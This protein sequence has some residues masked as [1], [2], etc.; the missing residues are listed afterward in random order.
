V[1]SRN[2]PPG[3][4]RNSGFVLHVCNEN[5][6][7]TGPHLHI[8][9]TT[10]QRLPHKAHALHRSQTTNCH[11]FFHDLSFAN[12]CMALYITAR[13]GWGGLTFLS[14]TPLAYYH[15][16]RLQNACFRQPGAPLRVVAK[17]CTTKGGGG[18]RAV[19]LPLLSHLPVCNH[20]RVIIG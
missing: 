18:T 11:L 7:P 4:A 14:R 8:H 13:D 5:L 6:F 20:E 12:T 1:C 9:S 2:W 3:I 17:I 19:A 10:T 15:T 16:L